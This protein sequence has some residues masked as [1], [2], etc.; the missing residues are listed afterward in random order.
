MGFEAIDNE[1]GI[2]VP[3]SGCRVLARRVGLA[4]QDDS[5]VIRIF[6]GKRV[7]E[8]VKD[9]PRCDVLV[10]NGEDH[11]KLALRFR[12]TGGAFKPSRNRQ[13]TSVVIGSKSL[14]G[15]FSTRFEAFDVLSVG[16]KNDGDCVTFSF[17]CPDDFWACDDD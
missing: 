10:G 2:S 11:G 8:T 6:L 14:S 1:A 12:K 9:F 15:L 13:S 5:S 3:V 7:G 4:G 17:E 16:L